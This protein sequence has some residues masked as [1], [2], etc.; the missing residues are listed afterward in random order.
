MA[1]DAAIVA[2]RAD[3]LAR[4]VPE[5]NAPLAALAAVVEAIS[6]DHAPSDAPTSATKNGR[7]RKMGDLLGRQQHAAS[8]LRIAVN[9]ISSSS[10]RIKELHRINDASMSAARDGAETASSGVREMLCEIELQQRHPQWVAAA[11]TLRK[12]NEGDTSEEAKHTVV[13]HH[14][15]EALEAGEPSHTSSAV[16]LLRSVNLMG[17]SSLRVVA[18]A[19]GAAKQLQRAKPGAIWHADSRHPIS[20]DAHSVLNDGEP[21]LRSRFGQVDD[22]VSLMPLKGRGGGTIGVVVSAAPAYPDAFLQ[23]T[24]EAAGPLIERAWRLE[25]VQRLLSLTTDWLQRQPAVRR[26][27]S[28][29]SWGAGQPMLDPSFAA[30]VED[31]QPLFNFEG[32]GLRTWRMEIRFK[33]ESIGVL[34]VG[35]MSP[36][37]PPL[38]PLLTG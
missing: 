30:Y 20:I 13:A 29:V 17:T 10:Q 12:R 36:L 2:E 27:F 4:C 32:H 28:N 22:A 19:P 26:N 35:A 37:L 16:V 9:H 5:M 11:Q 31:W 15:I 21:K 1:S 8:K 7:R 33:R 34:E 6:A 25:R 38:L 18:S 14:L 3:P 23:S 24:C